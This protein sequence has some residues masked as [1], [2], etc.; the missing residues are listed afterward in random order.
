VR[1]F[2]LHFEINAF[3]YSSIEAEKNRYIFLEDQE[4]STE[5]TPEAYKKRGIKTIMKE[6]FFRLFAPIM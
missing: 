3:M 2:L 1:S 4:K 6:G 5:L